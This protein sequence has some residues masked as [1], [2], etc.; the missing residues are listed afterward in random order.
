MPDLIW[1]ILVF[2]GAAIGYIV[3][4]R[5]GYDDGW[6]DAVLARA[7]MGGDR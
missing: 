3:G 5:F 6:M 1:L 2:A 7:G 4:H